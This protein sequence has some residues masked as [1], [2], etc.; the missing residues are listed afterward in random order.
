MLSL[1]IEAMG[2]PLMAVYALAVAGLLL[3][4]WRERFAPRPQ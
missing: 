4:G 1:F 3:P 2:L